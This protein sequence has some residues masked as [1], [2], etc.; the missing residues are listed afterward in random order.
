MPDPVRCVRRSPVSRLLPGRNGSFLLLST[1]PHS[2]PQ[3]C[4]KRC[5]LVHLSSIFSTQVPK[6]RLFYSLPVTNSALTLFHTGGLSCSIRHSVTPFAASPRSIPSGCTCPVTRG[7]V[8]PFRS[9]PPPPLWDFTELPPTGNL[10][11]P[12]GHLLRRPRPSGCR[13]RKPEL[14]LPH[15]R[16]HPGHPHRLHTGLPPGGPRPAGPGCHRS[17]YNAM[18][19][20][21]LHPRYLSRPWLERAGVT[22]PISPAQAAAAL[23]A[24]PGIRA[25]TCHLPTYYGVRPTSPPPGRGVPCPRRPPPCRRGTRG[26]SPLS[27]GPLPVPAADLTVV[28]AHRTLP[29]PGSPP[30][31]FLPPPRRSCAGPGPSTAV[32]PPPIP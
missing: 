27:G 25:G 15:R 24:E 12:G 29:A 14:S 7:R 28:S 26:P 8:S 22:G 21:D 10:F 19:L 6:I 4:G 32:P 16:L 9:S 23:E 17:V 1:F 3:A 11:E 2:F 18:A 5:K 13:V 20:L 30:S 31:L